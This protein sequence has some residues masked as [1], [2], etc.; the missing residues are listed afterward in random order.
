M[1]RISDRFREAKQLVPYIMGGWPDAETG[2]NVFKALVEAGCRVVEIGVPY[3]DP[4]A[5]GPTIQKASE[6]ALAGGTNTDSVLEMIADVLKNIDVSP[7]LMVYYNLIYRYGM[8]RFAAAAAK[9]GVEGV[10]V[11]DLSVEECSDW[12]RAAEAHG[13]D[14]IFLAAPTSSP[15]RL[16]KIVEDS[17]GFVYA[18]SL[19]GVTGARTQLP[20]DL[21]GFIQAVKG[22]TELPVA[23]G[24]GVSRPE[25]ARE[26]A[27]FAD[28]IIVGSAFI[29]LIAKTAPERVSE[30][31]EAFA[32][33]LISAIRGA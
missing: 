6:T 11:P 22:R 23:V 10:I 30:A 26:I 7:V 4:L 32:L 19:T 8:E 3:S 17:S 9:A 27:K 33:S 15:K 25:Q 21:A 2:K 28:G 13:I 12:K 1:S 18:V 14:T 29:D 31:V 5:D 20:P 24:F 16:D